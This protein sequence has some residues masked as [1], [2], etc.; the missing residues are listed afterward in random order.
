MARPGARAKLSVMGTAV[1]IPHRRSHRR[2]MR[3]LTRAQPVVEPPPPERPPVEPPLSL[4]AV[5]A[6]WRRAFDAAQDAIHA[7]GRM[8][9]APPELHARSAQLARERAETAVLIDAIAAEE[10]LH[11][12]HRLSAPRATKRLLGLPSEVDALVFALDGVLTT[13][14]ELHAAAWEET[15][16]ELLVHRS[17][18]ARDHFAPWMPYNP[19]VDYAEH[20]HGRPRLEGIRS[21]LGSRGITLPEGTPD[22]RPGAETVH[23]LANRKNQMLRRRLLRHGV[24]AFEGSSR[25]IEAAREAGLRIAVVSSSAN[26][27]EILERS[28]LAPLIDV[29]VDGNVMREQRLRTR[30]APD[31]FLA[32]CRML[33][34]EPGDAA[35]FV[36]SSAGIA[37]LRAAGLALAVAVNRAA[38][39]RAEG[40]DRVVGALGDM[41]EPALRG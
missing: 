5:S 38:A 17:A 40:A 37:A 3:A 22:D 2:R 20:L 32:A 31:T 35:A 19:R 23:G 15:F 1:S 29:C 14:T 16:D 10:H 27:R 30:P 26:T 7:A 24:A 25:Y 9:F 39:P 28:G 6:R 33:G 13:S 18:G 12:T 4:D 8:P 41:L 11:L 34:V 21:F 36:T